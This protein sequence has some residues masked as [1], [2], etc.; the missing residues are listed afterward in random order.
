M[1]ECEAV[2]L[3]NKRLQDF[4]LIEYENMNFFLFL[5]SFYITKCF[6]VSLILLVSFQYSD[7]VRY[8]EP[9]FKGMLVQA[10]LDNREVTRTHT[11]KKSQAHTGSQ[12]INTISFC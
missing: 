8:V 6:L 5:L 9:C 12:L 2:I 1:Q 4:H 11:Q 7:Y 10:D 3:K